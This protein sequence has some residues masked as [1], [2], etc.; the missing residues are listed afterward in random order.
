MT[1]S[2]RSQRRQSERRTEGKEYLISDLVSKDEIDGNLS[3]R[4][5][6]VLFNLTGAVP[7]NHELVTG[8]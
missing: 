1:A 5:L 8:Q 3:I 6:P 2:I 4:I 7:K